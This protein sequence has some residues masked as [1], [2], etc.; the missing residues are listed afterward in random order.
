MQLL[1]MRPAKRPWVLP[2]KTTRAA[3]TF[4]G[5]LCFSKRPSPSNVEVPTHVSSPPLPLDAPGIC[6]CCPTGSYTYEVTDVHDVSWRHGLPSCGTSC[7]QPLS[8]APASHH[9]TY[10]PL[11]TG[12]C[13]PFKA[14]VPSLQPLTSQSP[15]RPPPFWDCYSMRSHAA[16]PTNVVK[17][18]APRLNER[19]LE[20]GATYTRSGGFGRGDVG[21]V[22]FN[23]RV[24]RFWRR[25]TAA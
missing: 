16:A 24:G 2:V 5:R 10:H 19:T 20:V 17:L 25:L 11:P 21:C 14:G 22:C 15:V 4:T 6:C 9:S 12:P 23:I 8:S 3:S 18:R 7:T 13:R 1:K